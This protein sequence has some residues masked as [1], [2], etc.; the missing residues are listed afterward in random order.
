MGVDLLRSALVWGMCSEDL[1]PA[2]VCLI[3]MVGRCWFVLDVPEKFG[4][5]VMLGLLL[6]GGLLICQGD[7]GFLEELGLSCDGSS[8]VSIAV[9][10]NNCCCFFLS[11]CDVFD[12]GR[13]DPT[14]TLFIDCVMPDTR[15]AEVCSIMSFKPSLC[16]ACSEACQTLPLDSSALA[17]YLDGV[18]VGVSDCR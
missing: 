15:L 9:L 3:V 11:F 16:P 5:G 6:F 14:L 12:A 18:G 2:T 1:L 17:A 10:R 13:V 7:A 4:D 8:G